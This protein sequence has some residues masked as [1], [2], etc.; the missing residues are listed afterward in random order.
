MKL[1]FLTYIN[2]S[3]SSLLA[4]KLSEQKDIFVLP[5]AE[6][7]LQETLFSNEINLYIIKNNILLALNNDIKFLHYDLSNTDIENAFIGVKSK[8]E[9]FVNIIKKYKDLH[10]PEANIIVFK[11]RDIFSKYDLVFNQLIGVMQTSI[12]CIIRDPRG[13]FYSQKSTVSPYSQRIMNKNP[14]VL[15]YLW[16]SFLHSISKIKNEII[17]VKFE[18]LI[19]NTDSKIYTI[20]EEL[21]VD[22][23]KYFGNTYYDI[24]PEK[25]KLIHENINKASD[26]TK[27]N[28]WHN[29]SKTN[30]RLI[31]S[32][33]KKYFLEQDYKLSN[34]DKLNIIDKI[35]MYYYKIR[36][37]FNIDKY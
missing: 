4:N 37:F 20:L 13:V 36:I 25:E 10:K 26:L 28:N 16:N 3:G 2:R 1:V 18:N 31:E 12:I 30:I 35:F 8:G 14:L 24:M 11:N 21:G 15:S 7:L 23:E 29:L 33:T 9:F 27:N 6:I 22:N 5:E 32:I 17:F 34:L 19:K